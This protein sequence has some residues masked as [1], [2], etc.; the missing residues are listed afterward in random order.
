LLFFNA[1]SSQSLKKYII[2]DQRRTSKITAAHK[3]K[4]T[5]ALL[6]TQTERG[7]G[8]PNNGSGLINVFIAITY[9]AARY[10]FT[11]F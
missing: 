3:K 6:T 8:K 11:V 1:V 10:L 9:Q 5:H 7:T 2:Q 4:I